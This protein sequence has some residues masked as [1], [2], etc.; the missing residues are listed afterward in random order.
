MVNS[1][2]KVVPVREAVGEVLCHDITRIVPGRFK[3]RAYKKGHII[4]RD[5]IPDLLNIGKEHI[6]IL[7]L[8][9]KNVH[10][11]QAAERISRAT[12]GQGI[13]FTEPS[14]GRINM[15]AQ[16][17]GLLKVNQKALYKVNAM[18]EIVLTTLHNNQEVYTEQ[19]L[20]GTRIIPLYIKEKKLQWIEKFCRDNGP[21]VE[22]KPFRNFNVGLVVTGSEVY[23]K[24]IKDKFGPV[25]RSKFDKLGSHVTETIFVSDDPAMTVAAIHSLVNKNVDMVVLTGGMSVDPDDQTPAAIRQS[26][27]KTVLYGAPTFPGAMFML[28]YLG[29]VPV[30]GLPGCVMY[31]KATIFD[32]VIPRLLA[33]EAVTESDIINLGHGGFC[34][35]C[36]ECRFPLCGFGKG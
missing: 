11:N 35:G 20:A 29:E 26:G 19:P 7:N 10:E 33:G 24:R 14:E 17:N 22:I 2:M 4:K 31:H 15:T 21:I 9:K 1:M 34:A 30:I 18:G 5:D 25:V 36:A 12:A 23:H 8:D 6:Y 16:F 13:S 27:A 3:G 28:S 32:L